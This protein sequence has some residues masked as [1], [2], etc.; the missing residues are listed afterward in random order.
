MATTDMMFCGYNL[1]YLRFFSD[2]VMIMIMIMINHQYPQQSRDSHFVEKDDDDD[3]EVS[4]V[5]SNASYE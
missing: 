4:F 2:R 5:F 1:L 3:S